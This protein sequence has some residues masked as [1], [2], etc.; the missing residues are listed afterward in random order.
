MLLGQYNTRQNNK[1][2]NDFDLVLVYKNRF[3]NNVLW[4]TKRYTNEISRKRLV[5]K[6][7]EPDDE[8][9]GCLFYFYEKS[10]FVID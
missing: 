8:K 4:F 10:E 1:F 9:D 7:G 3:F 2:G 5:N 6:Y